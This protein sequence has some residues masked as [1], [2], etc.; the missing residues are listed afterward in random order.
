MNE[1]TIENVFLIAESDYKV[2]QTSELPLLHVLKKTEILTKKMFQMYC[3]N[4]M[5][6]EELKS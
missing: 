1:C 3:L 6:K 2:L 5:T 4:Q